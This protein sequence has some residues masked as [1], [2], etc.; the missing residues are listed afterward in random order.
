MRVYRNLI[1]LSSLAV[2]AAGLTLTPSASADSVWVQ[3][4]QRATQSEE[5]AAQP[6]DTPWQAE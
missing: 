6:G 2:I 5:C 1:T 3:S 4:Y